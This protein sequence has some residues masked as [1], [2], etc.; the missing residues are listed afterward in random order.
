MPTMVMRWILAE[1]GAGEDPHSSKDL[2]LQQRI[3]KGLVRTASLEELIDNILT[4]D[5]VKNRKVDILRDERARGWMTC[6]S[7]PTFFWTTNLHRNVEKN[8]KA[9]FRSDTSH[10][11]SNGNWPLHSPRNYKPAAGSG[12]TQIIQ[13]DIFTEF[14]WLIF[15]GIWVMAASSDIWYMQLCLE[16]LGQRRS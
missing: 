9:D 16:P 4:E 14:H 12:I 10:I 5:K 13:I 8:K 1:M 6:K 3:Q 15:A 2:R 11:R 7:V